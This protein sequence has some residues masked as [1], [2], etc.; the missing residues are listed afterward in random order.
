MRRS[1]IIALIIVL[2]VGGGVT[3]GASAVAGTGGSSFQASLSGYSEV[4]PISTLATGTFMATVT[5]NPTTIHYELT[6]FNLSSMASAAHIH[7]GQ[8]SVNGGIVA[9]LCGG[10]GKPTCPAT[11]GSVSGDIVAAD[12]LAVTTQGIAAGEMNEV[13]R[14]MVRGVS[15]VNVHSANFG[16]GEIRG[17]VVRA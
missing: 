9:F 12:I 5:A 1:N 6:Y 10:G 3:L 13:L 17:Q 16:S 14:A 15:Y 11:G 8:T 2:G 7:F 4:P